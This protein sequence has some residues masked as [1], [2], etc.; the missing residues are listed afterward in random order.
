M[1]GDTLV[2]KELIELGGRPILWHVMRI[3]S[4]YGHTRFIIALGYQA[5]AVKRYFLEYRAMSHDI[6]IRLDRPSTVDCHDLE[7]EDDWEITMADTG[8]DAEKGARV[9]RVAR[10][11]DTDAFF[12]TYGEAVGNVDIRALLSFHREHGRLATVTGTR[13]RSHL[14]VFHLDEALRVTGFV[15][16]PQLDYWVNAGFMVFQRGVLDYLPDGDAVHL[17]A[18]VLPRLA[19]D[20]ELMM[21]QHLGYWR[22]MKTFKDALELDRIWEESAPWKVW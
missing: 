21:Y 6:T 11:I 10:Y 18:E 7:R 2:K 17:E 15:E 22:S 14:G 9:R 5:E 12:V 8:L 16:K 20:G 19:A 1:R 3:F 13:L 4:A